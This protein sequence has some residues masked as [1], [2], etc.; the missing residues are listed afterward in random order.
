MPTSPRAEDPTTDWARAVVAGKIVSGEFAIM[1]AERHLRDIVD[2]PKRG[3]H[4]RPEKAV[5]PLGFFPTCLSVTAGDQAGEPFRLIRYMP[6]VVGN[7]FGWHRDDGRRRYRSAWL[8]AAKGGAK[9]L[10]LDTPI[11]TPGGWSTMGALQ[12]GDTI[13]DENGAP[14][15][16]TAAHPV[17]L[18]SACYR[19]AFSDGFSIVADAGHRWPTFMECGGSSSA[20]ELRTTEEIAATLRRGSRNHRIAGGRL[21][22]GCR[23]VGSV[24]VRCISVDSPSRLFLAGANLVPTHNSPLL[25][26]L[27]LYLFGFDGTSRAEA[28]AVAK[29]RTQS[30]V[31]F[32]DAVSMCRA[33]MPGEGESLV[34]AGEVY[35]RGEGNNAWMIEHPRTGSKFQ[36]LAGEEAPSGPRPTVVAA[37]EI[38]EW[39]SRYAIDM[40]K[41]AIGKVPGNALLLLATNTPAVDQVVG[42]ELSEEHQ[43]I[44]RR[45]A[46]DDGV[47]AIIFRVDKD[48]APLEDE[49]CWPK[50]MPLI[51]AVLPRDNVRDM[52]V[53]AQRSMATRLMVQRLFFGI[54]VGA[55][56]YWI[57]LDS[58]E[59]CLGKVDPRDYLGCDC[60]LSLDLSQKNDLTALGVTWRKGDLLAQT[61]RYWKPRDG[62]AGVNAPNHADGGQ[63]RVWEAEG[64]LEATPGLSIDYEF[65]A[66]EAQ[67][68][69]V[70]HRVKFIAID[71]AHASEF[72][73]ACDRIGFAVWVW[74]GPDKPPGRG[75]PIVI[76]SQGRAG[77]HSTKALWMP[78]SVAQL[79]DRVLTKRLL[80]DASPITRWNFGNV[81]VEADA[82]KNR[83]FVKKRSRGR[84][85]GAVVSAMGVGAAE[86]GIE[87]GRRTGSYLATASEVL[88][89]E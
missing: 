77:M 58:F 62:D 81:A 71:P 17:V 9:A 76:H 74:E 3:I 35:I 5:R 70:T 22:V 66:K 4:W 60:W 64:D 84:I 50:A 80:L 10:A 87:P 79:E 41:N 24:P 31:L 12:V 47:F 49:A 38:H 25:A 37:D 86:S 7:L 89:L 61:I 40:W 39:K 16:V 63:Y 26:A 78:R 45:E 67:R 6:F 46:T 23:P 59:A 13:F 52:V 72:F 27:S 21:I 15:R 54:R 18:G 73:K 43:Q 28:Y 83:Y 85:D 82:S 48:D 36:P 33:P 57:D 68:W 69:C 8:E 2:G 30:N 32:M 55:A 75:V 51:D 34:D 44:L 53:T 14:C 29:D 20:E 42:S 11:A 1:A 19:V 56:E 88:L 65:V